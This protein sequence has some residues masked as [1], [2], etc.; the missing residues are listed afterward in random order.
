M[1]DTTT[2]Q[3][4]AMNQHPDYTVP[5]ITTFNAAFDAIRDEPANAEI[6]PY[7]IADAIED[8]MRPGM[9]AEELIT[10]AAERL[11]QQHSPT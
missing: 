3:E 1:P 4:P 5:D 7:L 9:T 6:E 2:N 8:A 10:A 11:Q